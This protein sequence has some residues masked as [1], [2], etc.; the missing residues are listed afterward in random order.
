MRREYGI[1]DDELVIGFA[2]RI[3]E[4]K[5]WPSVP[6]LVKA[7]TEAGVKYKV[8]LVLSVYEERDAQIVADIKNGIVDS[9]GQDNLIYMQDLSQSEIAD[10]YY[11]VD[12]FVMTSMFESFGKAA[13]EAMSRKC[14]VLSTPVGGLP[15]VI[16]LEDNL[17]NMSDM[18]VFVARVKELCGN[19]ELLESQREYFYNRYKNLYT[20]EIN[21]IKHLEVYKQVMGI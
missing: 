3:S 16:G 13:V 20:K 21:V 1:Q 14:A 19:K 11:M 8:A 10:Y 15:E 12:I 9:I 17:Y 7:L 4:E 5:D 2:G 18:D 6:K